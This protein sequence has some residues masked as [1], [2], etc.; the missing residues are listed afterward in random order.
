MWIQTSALH[1]QPARPLVQGE[2]PTWDYCRLQWY[3]NSNGC[4]QVR[5]AVPFQEPC[6]LTWL[7]PLCCCL[8]TLTAVHFPGASCWPVQ[9]AAIHLA[10]LA[11]QQCCM[12]YAP[13]CTWRRNS[14]KGNESTFSRYLKWKSHF[15]FWSNIVKSTCTHIE[16]WLHNSSLLQ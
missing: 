15:R 6:Q 9:C 16:V 13:D 2:A 8:L 10:L 7:A 12:H 1:S 11:P 3:E 14:V 5:T 4:A